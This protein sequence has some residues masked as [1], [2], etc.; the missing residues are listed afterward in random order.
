MSLRWNSYGR[1]LRAA[2]M[3]VDQC[4]HGHADRQAVG[5][6][7]LD[8]RLRAV[9]HRAVD[10]HAAV[11]RSRM[12]HDRIAARELEPFLGEPV[13]PEVLLRIRNVVELGETLTLHA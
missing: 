5:N 11:H 1:S 9:S 8:H 12:H 10:L 6:L 2:N 3:A 13:A 4:E 7:L